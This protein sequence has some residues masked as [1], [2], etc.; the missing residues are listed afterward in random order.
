VDFDDTGKA[1]FD[2]IYTQPDP[3]AYFSTLREF[4]YRI[5]ELA[6]PYFMKLIQQCRESR[7]ISTPNVL[8]IGCSYGVNAALL[9]CDARMDDLYDRYCGQDAD[10][11]TR[12]MLLARDRDLVRSR[13]GPAG[14]RFVGLDSSRPALSYALAAGFIDGAVHADLERRDP[15]E[16]ERGQFAG[17]DLVISTGVLGYIS[18][19]TIS[20]VVSANGE[21]KP[22]MAHFVLRMFPFEPVAETLAGSGYETVHVD[23]VFK[24]R[25]F[26]SAEEQTLILDTLS[27]AGVDP[28]GLESDGWL[29]AQLYL[30]RPRGTGNGVVFDLAAGQPASEATKSSRSLHQRDRG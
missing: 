6:K 11:Q 26:T 8:D 10:T 9:R 2:H 1:S 30:S 12:S 17:T 7:G 15:S 16:E 21:R 29:Y 20:R 25:R 13:N 4:D 14:A 19:K 27:V 3:R 28:Q 22:W 5:P 18:D 23:R 24:Q